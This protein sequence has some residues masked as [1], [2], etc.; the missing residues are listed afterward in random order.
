MFEHDGAF[1]FSRVGGKHELH[2]YMR[3]RR[4]DLTLTN[5]VLVYLLQALAPQRLHCRQ[6]LVGLDRALLLDRGVLL[7]QTNQ[8][9]RNGIRLREPF[10]R[11]M[12]GRGSL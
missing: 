4:R 2:L 9:K 12:V 5:I 8:L 11:N 6:P 10:Q 3:Q 7:H 1:R